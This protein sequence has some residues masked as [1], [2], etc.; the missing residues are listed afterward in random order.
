MGQREQVAWLPSGRVRLPTVLGGC[1][2]RES[3]GHDEIFHG[4]DHS[5]VELGAGV[6]DE[7]GHH[8]FDGSEDR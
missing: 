3:V 2:Y 5:G 7:L 1:E 8:H 6:G 4:L